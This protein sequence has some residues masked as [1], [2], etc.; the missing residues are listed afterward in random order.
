MK[1]IQRFLSRTRNVA[2]AKR[3]RVRGIGKK[4]EKPA[5][6]VSSNV[7]LVWAAQ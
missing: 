2:V 4:V 6:N 1:T 3:P 5:A 7:L